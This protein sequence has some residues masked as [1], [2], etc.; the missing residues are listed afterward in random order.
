MKAYRILIVDD[1]AT[2]VD[3]LLQPLHAEDY[4][5]VAALDGA[6][7]L[8]LFQKVR[9]DLVILDLMMPGIDGFAV[10]A[11]IRHSSQVPV[12]VLSARQGTD[13]KARALN[14]GADDYLTKPFDLDELLARVH[15]LRRRVLYGA[16]DERADIQ[17]FGRLCIDPRKRRVTLGDEPI[18]LT[19]TEYALLLEFAAHPDEVLLHSLLLQRIWGLEHYKKTQ[20]LHV[21]VQR[22]R[23]KIEDDPA[24][25]RYIVTEPGVGYRFYPAALTSPSESTD[26]DVSA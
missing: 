2:L 3:L 26:A 19:P 9:P 22:L 5:V 6:T 1:D 11:M 12:L 8:D 4:Q 18:Y 16:P 17:Q 25:P 20:Y 24:N 10:L 15:A 14:E 21:Y 7:G 13:I 23:S